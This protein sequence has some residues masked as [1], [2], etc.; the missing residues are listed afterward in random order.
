M[1]ELLSPEVIKN[2]TEFIDLS[3]KD[4]KAELECKVLYKKITQQDIADRILEKIKTLSIGTQT[5]ENRMTLTYMPDNLRVNVVTPQLIHKVCV[6]GSFKD[7]PVLVEKKQNYFDNRKDI[8]DV[9]DL[10]CKFTLRSEKE[11]RKDWD[12]SPNDTKA[13]VRIMN[14]KSFKTANQLFRIDFSLVK[15]RPANSKQSLS[16]T[17]KEEGEYELEIEFIDK[18]TDVESKVIAKDLFKIITSLLQAYHESPFLLKN[19]DVETYKNEF[20]LTKTIMWDLVTLEKRHLNKDLPN[21]IL[22]DYTVTI[23]A[24]G[25]R[26]GLYIARDRKVLLIRNKS[27]I[28][29]WTGITAKNDAYVG[30]FIDGELIVQKNLFCIFDVYRYKTQDV[31][32][33]PLLSNDEDLIKNPKR[34]RLG[35]AQLFVKDLNTDFIMNPSATPLEVQTKL[36]Y[37]GDGI[38]MEEAIN[39]LLDTKYEYETDGLIFTPRLSPVAPREDTRMS[40]WNKVYKWKPSHQ[41]SIDFLLR[42]NPT[43]T[44]DPKTGE[45]AKHGELFVTLTPKDYFI[46]PRETVN[47]EYIPK[48]YEDEDVKVPAVFQP[49]NPKDPDAYHIYIPVDGRNRPVDIN[50]NVVKDNTIIECSFDIEKYKW[51]VMRTR[52]DKTFQHR[53]LKRANF[54]N[55]YD[56]ADNIWTSMHIPIT[57]TTIR[58]IQSNPPSEEYFDNAYYNDEL[59]LQSRAFKDITAFHNVIKYK[60]Y[61]NNVKEKD[62][63]LELASGRDINKWLKVKPEKVVALDISLPNFVAPKGGACVRY[64]ELKRDHP[65]RYLPPVLFVEGNMNTYPLFEQE[66]S[67]MEILR[68]ERT[69]PTEYL[70]KFEQLEKFDAISCQFAMHYA[71]ESEEVFRSFAKNIDKYGKKTFFGTCSDGASIYSLLLGKKSNI[72][73]MEKKLVGEYTKEYEDKETWTDEEFG[74]PVKVMLE[75]FDKPITE[76]LVPWTKVVNIMSDEGWQLEETHLFKDL[77]VQQ[78]NTVLSQDQQTFSFLNRSFVF[79]KGKK[80]E[81]KEE[82]KKE[83]PKEEP[84]KEEEKKVEEEKPKKRKLRKELEPEEEPILFSGADE[85][86]GEYRYMSN[87][88]EYPIEIDGQKYPTVEH[89]F[90]AMKAKTFE[91]EEMYD[92]IVKTKTPKAAKAAGKKVKNFITE[93]WE[94]KREEIMYKGVRAKFV[95]HPELRKKLLETD[96]KVIGKADARNTFWA[97]GTGMESDKAK[98]PSKWRGQNKLGKII[99]DLRNTLKDETN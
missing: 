87:D 27:D 44:F 21:N 70:A 57:E 2:I 55:R 90:Q 83:E 62:V 34:C 91:D 22:K 40:T 31:K 68:G 65:E 32:N 82:P 49:S 60:L 96:K 80:P 92:K 73:M 78:T 64:L 47:G 41:N 74:M 15:T 59:K 17:L 23:K 7:V 38:A 46:Y 36:F 9:S 45:K 77:Y 13:H 51:V 37:A 12:G 30:T 79:K 5:E 86:K 6:Q 4:Q 81:P 99:M 3:K 39:A 11:V 54:G 16:N 84:K 89:Y 56:V 20:R 43:D 72:F 14:R 29:T 61:E 93:V 94:A 33:L 75:T 69:A 8:I 58:S 97:I 63:L 53:V 76:W 71:C 50:G 28:I 24:D 52:Y 67:Y 66:D 1:E 88:A 48:K 35:F 26:C 19:S 10:N 85:S 98:T 95:Q 42:M 25:L 18:K